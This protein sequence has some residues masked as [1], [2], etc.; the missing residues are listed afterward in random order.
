MSGPQFILPLLQALIHGPECAFILHQHRSVL[1]SLPTPPAQGGLP[2][3]HPALYLHKTEADIVVKVLL[4]RHAVEDGDWDGRQALGRKGPTLQH[5]PSVWHVWTLGWG[6]AW[7]C[8]GS[9]EVPMMQW[10]KENWL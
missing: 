1:S 6:S 7:G 5:N 2:C 3:P 9:R 8:G 4:M 10:G